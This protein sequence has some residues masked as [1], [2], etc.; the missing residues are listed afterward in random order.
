VDAI[1]ARGAVVAPVVY[2]DAIADAVQARLSG[3][4]AVLAWVDPIGGGEDR[5][6]FDGL[7]QALSAAGVFVSAHPDV[8]AAIGTKEILFTTRDLGWGC[9]V[10][11]YND[12]EALR[13]E[14]PARLG[15]GP[16]V[17]KRERGNA[18]IG[19]WRV[20]RVDDARVLVQ[21]AHVRELGGQVV[22]FAELVD[23]CEPCFSAGGCVIDQAFQPRIAEGLIRV[24]LVGDEVVGYAR[25]TADSLLV[26]PAD[27]ARVMGLPSPKEMLPAR[28]PPFQRLRETFEHEWLPAMQRIVGI[29]TDRL[30]LLWDADFLLG[31][32]TS[33]GSDSYVLCEINAS[34]VTPFPPEAIDRVATAAVER[35]RARRR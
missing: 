16:R 3:F 20:E 19:V 15:L 5:V 26:E 33:E 17:L 30:P 2:R 11:R 27:A 12:V 9:D 7:L 29:T 13:H 10:H 22:T 8:I 23:R 1:A 24:Y 31:P 18:G 28:H 4:D 25:Q 14:L 21:E 32:T 35:A 34:C 6:R